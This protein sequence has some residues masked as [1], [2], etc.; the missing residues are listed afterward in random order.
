MP[1]TAKGAVREVQSLV[2]LSSHVGWSELGVHG[3]DD[4]VALN[5]TT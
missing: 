3:C 5:H 4:W 1:D 2:L